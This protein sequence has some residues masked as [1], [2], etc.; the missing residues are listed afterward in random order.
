MATSGVF[1]GPRGA[2]SSGPYLELSWSRLSVD[3]ANNRSSIRLTLKLYSTYN[4]NFSGT[5]QGVLEGSA[6]SYSSGMSGAGNRTI[7]TRDLW[8]NH[9]SNGSK[10]IVFDATFAI[11]INW[12]GVYLGSLSVSGTASLDTIPRASTLT[13]FSFP[14]SLQTSTETRIDY[15]VGRASTAFRHKVELVDGS[16]VLATWDNQNT[17]GS[18]SVNLT[19]GQVNTILSRMSTVSSRGFTLRVTTRSGDNG[20]WIGSSV[21]RNATATVHTNIVPSASGMSHSQVGNNV[22]THYLQNISKIK[23]SFNAS[24]TGGASVSRTSIVVRC[25]SGSANSQTINGTS[26]TT[27]RVVTLSGGYEVIGTVTDSRGRSATTRATFT[28]TEYNPPS[29]KSFTVSRDIKTPSIVNIYRAGNVTALGTSNKGVISIQKRSGEGAWSNVVSPVT[30]NGG[31]YDGNLTSSSNSV[32]SSFEFKLVISDSFGERSESSVIV[33]TQ[34]VVLDIYKNEGIG[35]GKMYERGAMDISG[36][37]YINGVSVHEAYPLPVGDGSLAYWLG[38]KQGTYFGTPTWKVD[39][40]PSSYGILTMERYS[41]DFS[42]MWKCQSWGYIYR[43]S[44]NNIGFQG[45]AGAAPEWQVVSEANKTVAQ[46]NPVNIPMSNGWRFYGGDY[47]PLQCVMHSDRL[48]T[49]RGM[50]DG[51]SQSAGVVLGVLPVGYR[52][53]NR[54]IFTCYA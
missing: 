53:K 2:T 34:E 8:V 17:T 12:S 10:S 28:I 35:V 38:I 54:E 26:G 40:A 14:Y 6:F 5:Q 36:D 20:G 32:S 52:P 44:G 9:D 46:L 15:T 23:A 30:F 37:V 48:V 19:A 16:T 22:S 33:S 25:V 29:I 42:V 27:D 4:I 7:A 49:I 50:I 13:S 3:V 47:A 39:G 41:T 24:S 51:G 43:L 11:K 45:K 21:T 18:S 31:A 1:T